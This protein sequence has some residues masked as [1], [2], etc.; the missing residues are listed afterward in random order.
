[1][2]YIVMEIQAGDSVA[3][4]VTQHDTRQ[5]A[6]SKFHQILA[7]AAISTVPAHSAVMMSDEGFPLRNE[8][9]KH[10]PEPVEPEENE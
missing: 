6:E 2:K 10:E 1:M 7:S 4:V 5:A 3:T 9:Y 8:C